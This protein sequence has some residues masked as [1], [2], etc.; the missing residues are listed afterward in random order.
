MVAI[1]PTF[2][3]LVP[4]SAGS[5]ARFYDVRNA[6][7][8]ERRAVYAGELTTLGLVTVFS[9]I[10]GNAVNQLKA[11]AQTMVQNGER[12]LLTHAMEKLERNKPA[13][14][15]VLAFASNILAEGCSRLIFPRDLLWKKD[16]ESVSG[17]VGDKVHPVKMPESKLESE[18][19][20]LNSKKNNPIHNQP[21]PFASRPLAVAPSFSKP[22]PFQI[23]LPAYTSVAHS[24]FSV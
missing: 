20:S 22:N 10:L 14:F 23:Q 18:A 7:K 11:H 12:N 19:K 24:N 2:F 6:P 9:S 3:S 1:G 4:K 17:K 16:K 15:A 5:L 13:F 8:E 21:I